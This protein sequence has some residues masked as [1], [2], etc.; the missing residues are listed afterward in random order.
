V[1]YRRVAPALSG[2]RPASKRG[3]ICVP[4]YYFHI[5]TAKGALVEDEEGVHLPDLAAAREEARLTAASLQ[6][7]TEQGGYD[8]S[9][10]YFE[11]LSADGQEADTVPAFVRRLVA[12]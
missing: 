9:D 2:L 5:R 4:R 7:D 1:L 12:V 11:I 10:S 3:S 6:T 8:Y